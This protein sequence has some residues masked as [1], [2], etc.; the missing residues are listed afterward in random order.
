MLHDFLI[1]RPFDRR[2]APSLS[3]AA[4]ISCTRASNALSPLPDRP[5]TA[6][7]SLG[8][9]VRA[10]RDETTAKEWAAKSDAVIL[11]MEAGELDA[12]VKRVSAWR[13][14]PVLW[15]CDSA[16]HAEGCQ[17]HLD[18]DGILFPGMSHAELH[19]AFML[20]SS[21]YLRRTQWQKEREQLLERLEERKWIERA[22]S[23][24]CE[25]KHFSEAE[26]YEF[27][28]KQAMNERK[29]MVDVA[30]SIVKVYQLIADNK[31][32]GRRKT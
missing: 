27:L 17:S 20:G 14:W 2:P 30:S 32:G 29:R 25:I 9:R 28:R 23:V 19:W 13:D 4:G 15:W 7:S 1:V 5:E 21:H 26:A 11:C 8:L 22:K 10:P 12:W 6:I 3:S 16:D 18:V 24:L 31:R